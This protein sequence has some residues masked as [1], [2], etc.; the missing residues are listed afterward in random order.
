[1]KKVEDE[2][3]EEELQDRMALRV[4]TLKRIESKNSVKKEDIKVSMSQ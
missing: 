4:L 2:V 1:M 3:M